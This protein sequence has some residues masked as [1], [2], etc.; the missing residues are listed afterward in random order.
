M[1]A[2]RRNR[3]TGWRWAVNFTH[4]PLYPCGKSSQYTFNRAVDDAQSHSGRL[5]K[6]SI[7]SLC[8]GS[9]PRWSSHSLTATNYSILAS[10]MRYQVA[11]S[12]IWRIPDPL[13]STSSQ[14]VTY[15]SEFQVL[16][17]FALLMTSVSI[18][19][20]F[21]RSKWVIPH[22]IKNMSIEP[23]VLHNTNKV[24]MNIGLRLV[25]TNNEYKM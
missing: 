5:E 6:K 25:K 4:W 2:Y 18:Y 24:Q 16:L 9:N 12:L 3:G 23:A 8:Q 15:W 17:F 21:I 22:R 1:K 13:T 19:F 14:A 20:M 11:V 7:S 10:I